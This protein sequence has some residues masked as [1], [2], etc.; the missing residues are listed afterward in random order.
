MKY[1]ACIDKVEIDAGLVDFVDVFAVSSGLLFG[2]FANVA[3]INND[4]FYTSL[5]TR[6]QHFMHQT[7]P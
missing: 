1:V 3:I 2:W 5:I 6:M 7:F 4:D